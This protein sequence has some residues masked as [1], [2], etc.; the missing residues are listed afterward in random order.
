VILKSYI[1]TS[2]WFMYYMGSGTTG[3]PNNVQVNST[4]QATTNQTNVEFTS[5]GFTVAAGWTGNI[6]GSASSAIFMAWA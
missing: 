1:G 5:T 3:Y 2:N 4:A 6:T